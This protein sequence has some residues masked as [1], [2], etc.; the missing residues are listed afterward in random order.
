MLCY[1]FA[2]YVFCPIKMEAFRLSFSVAAAN[3]KKTENFGN[4]NVKNVIHR[5][6]TINRMYL[7]SLFFYSHEYI[8]FPLP[9]RSEGRG[10]DYVDYGACGYVKQ[11]M[12]ITTAL[13]S[14]LHKGGQSLGLLA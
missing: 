9:G 8:Q 7:F 4:L 11:W 5:K 1:F 12:C 14:F 2:F 10:G 3:S 6:T 13:S